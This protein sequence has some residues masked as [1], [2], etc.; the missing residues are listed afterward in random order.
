MS[1][2]VR[3][4]SMTSY[5]IHPTTGTPAACRATKGRCPFGTS[6]EHYDSKAA[7]RSAF[8]AQMEAE[9][10]SKASY[11]PEVA[12]L[13]RG[14]FDYHVQRTDD[15]DVKAMLEHTKEELAT[16]PSVMKLNRAAALYHAAA[17][18]LGDEA[19]KNIARA[20]ATVSEVADVLKEY[21]EMMSYESSSGTAEQ[22][23]ELI[24]AVKLGLSKLKRRNLNRIV[25]EESKA[26]TV[27]TEGY[28]AVIVG[29]DLDELTV[30]EILRE[31]PSDSVY[32]G[33]AKEAKLT[34]AR[35]EIEARAA[36]L[37]KAFSNDGV[38]TPPPYRKK[39][40]NLPEGFSYLSAGEE[41]NVYLHEA[42]AT[43]YKIP[44]DYSASIFK[45]K[46]MDLNSKEGKRHALNAVVFKAADAYRRLDR[47]ALDEKL[48]AE[49]L[50]T[51]FLTLEDDE[52]TPVG[53]IVQPYLDP[54]RY[55]VYKPS[56]GEE[57]FEQ[58]D[59]S[60]GVTDIHR[61][62]VRLDRKSGKLV[63]FDCLFAL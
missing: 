24:R 49:Y 17:N 12:Q 5:H 41:A 33:E 26:G 18:E 25:L 4:Y 57:T 6:Q 30:G 39:T 27:E 14:L 16:S 61:G 45:M 10:R 47:K 9:M 44:H 1:K 43:V 19:D 37:V 55:I 62:N 60:I 48:G 3:K 59:K 11:V 52:S 36:E 21:Y 13:V 8:E 20:S 51:H 53:M 32:Y 34:K 50:S 23:K 15:I 31:T 40:D 28:K 35:Q 29:D 63:L 38:F 7:A 46:E 54:E 22:K 2:E 42:T 58:K 56:Y